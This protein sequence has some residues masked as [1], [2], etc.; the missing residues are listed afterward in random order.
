MRILLAEDD[1]DLSNNIKDF[2]KQANYVV[3]TVTNCVDAEFQG[4]EIEYALV[5]LDI[6]LPKRS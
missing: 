3:E 6:G 4:D 5:I 2:L 1:K